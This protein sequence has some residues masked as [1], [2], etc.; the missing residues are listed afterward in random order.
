VSGVAAKENTFRFS[1]KRV[2]EAAELLLYECRAYYSGTG[3]WLSR[4]P[5]GEE[6]GKNLYGFVANNPINAVDQLGL[7]IVGFYGADTSY[8]WPHGRYPDGTPYGNQLLEEIS[9]I[10][11]MYEKVLRP[12]SQWRTY[13]LYHSRADS[14]AFSDLLRYLDT[15]KD[16]YYNPPCDNEETIKLFGWSWGGASAV[17]LANRINDS[18]KFKKKN[19]GLV[20]VI[21]PVTAFRTGKHTVPSNVYRL[22]NRYQRNGRNVLPLGLP[23][24]GNEL[25]IADPGKT[26]ANQLQ[27]DP[28]GRRDDVD[29]VSIVELV[30]YDF[31]AEFFQ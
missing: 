4:D 19:V 13:P 23:N 14:Q 27:L 11:E 5:I 1:T 7:I 30:A 6:G 20:A 28:G 29:H 15:N 22:W 26:I 25:T 17:E 3:R 21:D 9:G 31:L 2:N 12:G 10:M 18:D 24:H 16:G 8:R